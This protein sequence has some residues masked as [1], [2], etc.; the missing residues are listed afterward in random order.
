[1]LPRKIAPLVLALL[2]APCGAA[3]AQVTQASCQTFTRTSSS[4]PDLV[5]RWLARS[6]DDHVTV[7]TRTGSGAEADTVPLYSGES[8][9]TRQGAVCSYSSHGLTRVGTGAATQLRRYERSDALAMAVAGGQCPQPH[10]AAAA[11]RYTETYDVSPAAFVS[12]MELWAAAAASAQTLDREICCEGRSAPS[13]AARNA[14]AA[15][16]IG[17]RLRAAI[18]A[19]RMKSAPATRIVRISGLALRRRYALFLVDPDAQ[20]A[21]STLYVIY[22]SRW[23][24]GAWHITGVADAAS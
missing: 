11:Q 16:A 3:R 10:P 4:A 19:G 20:P 6:T 2:L 17:R 23:V 8:G 14:L 21:G 12:I 13:G 24:A 18:D 5:R 15:S 7:C 22:L 1:M 9:V